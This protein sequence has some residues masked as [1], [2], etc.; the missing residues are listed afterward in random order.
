MPDL[1]K[2]PLRAIELATLPTRY[3]LGKLL[4]LGHSDDD[5]TV[6]APVEAEPRPEP[7]QSAPRKPRAKPKAKPSPKAARRATRKEPTKGEAGQIR[8]QQHMS[9]QD[10]G[11]PGP[12][13]TIDVAAPWEGYDA[14][15]EDQVLDR[16]TGA[17]PTLRAMVRLYESTHGGR[18]QILIATEEQ[19]VQP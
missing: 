10:A 1:L 9:E 15:T 18:R 16:L 7:P 5:D 17:E 13:A 2:L 11:G 8:Q 6:A 4:D 19:P 12:G 14:M 3:V